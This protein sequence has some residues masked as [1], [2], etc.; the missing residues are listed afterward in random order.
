MQSPLNSLAI[1][2]GKEEI[3]DEE[4]HHYLSEVSIQG[5]FNNSKK[6]LVDKATKRRSLKTN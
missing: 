5:Q 3:E 2:R 6:R 4:D 1:N